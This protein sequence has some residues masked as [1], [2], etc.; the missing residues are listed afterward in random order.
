MIGLM[1]NHAILWGAGLH[2]DNLEREAEEMVEVSTSLCQSDIYYK[3]L[4]DNHCRKSSRREIAHAVC[5]Q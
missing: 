5:V 2:Q 4:P 3:L 1:T